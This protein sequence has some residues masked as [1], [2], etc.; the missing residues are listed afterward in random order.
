MKQNIRSLKSFGAFTLVEMLVVMS[1]MGILMTIAVLNFRDMNQKSGIETE[2]RTLYTDLMEVRLD[3]LYTKRPRSVMLSATQFS[4]YSS[5]NTSVAALSRK[6]LRHPVKWTPT[7][8]TLTINFD[9]CGLCSP[10]G[11]DIP[12]CVA[13]EGVLGPNPAAVDSLVVS[14]V[15]VKLGKLQGGS[16]VTTGITQQ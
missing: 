6:T 16:C 13:P 3:A 1:I 7:S 11:P 9:T 8:P 2:A 5:T 14:S 12:I 4:V 15:R 10:T